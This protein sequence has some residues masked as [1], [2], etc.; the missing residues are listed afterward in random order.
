M[1]RLKYKFMIILLTVVLFIVFVP[2]IPNDIFKFGV[3]NK[4]YQYIGEGNTFKV[5]KCL[6]NESIVH[7]VYKSPLEIIESDKNRDKH[8]PSF[9]IY[10]EKKFQKITIVN[11]FIYLVNKLHR[12]SLLKLMKK[13]SL[14]AD[15]KQINWFSYTQSK[16]SQ[17]TK[18]NEKKIS[19]LKKIL[20]I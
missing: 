14:F 9:I 13:Y 16:M 12:F 18:Y 19:E 5:Y 8:L 7:K 2:I 17:L 3:D 1:P 10:Y 11:T 4:V 20:K 6:K 15:V